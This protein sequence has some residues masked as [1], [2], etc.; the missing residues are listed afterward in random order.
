MDR[1]AQG[2][3][4]KIGQEV[5]IVATCYICKEQIAKGETYLRMTETGKDLC[6]SDSCKAEYLH[7]HVEHEVINPI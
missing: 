1:F 6:Y 4:D 2:F 7:R 3:P 5:E